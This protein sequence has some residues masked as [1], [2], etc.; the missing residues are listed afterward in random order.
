MLFMLFMVKGFL[1][2]FPEFLMQRMRSNGQAS[3]S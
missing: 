3:N 2:L 1:S